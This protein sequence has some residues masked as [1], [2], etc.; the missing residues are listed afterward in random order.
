MAAVGYTPI[1]LYYST[2]ATQQ[3]VAGNLAN[4]ELAINITDGKLY[5]KDNVGI[6]QLLASKSSLTSVDSITFGTTGLTPATATTG[7]VTVG[8]TLVAA[9]GGTGQSSYAV[10]DIVYASSTTA[11]SKLNIGSN[12]QVLMS[13][14][15]TPTW[16][17]LGSSAVT[18]FSGGTTGLTPNT[19]ATGSIT[20][21][22]TLNVANGGTGLTSLGMGY[23]PYGGGT[24]AFQASSSFKFSGGNVLAIGNFT[25]A[26]YPS[27]VNAIQFGASGKSAIENYDGGTTGMWWNASRNSSGDLVHT[28]FSYVSGFELTY[29]G[30]NWYTAADDAAGTPVILDTA[31]SLSATNG[32]QVSN[33]ISDSIGD[34]RSIPQTTTSSNYILQLSD[35]GKH[36]NYTLNNGSVEPPSLGSAPIGYV[37]TIFNNTNTTITIYE[38]GTLRQ[39]GTTNTGNRTLSPYGVATILCVATNTYVITGTGL[40]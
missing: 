28:T 29:N 40:N 39:G 16:A 25:P 21:G 11:L 10:G 15:S 19:A 37:A 24:S 26:S 9:N 14:G 23:I 20:L 13:N 6:V 5:Y 34:V 17:S 36:I 27:F 4:G 38:V 18:S 12:T 30:F 33:K 35:N 8:G 7:T 32:L 31:M 3:P 22:G 1:S 2:T